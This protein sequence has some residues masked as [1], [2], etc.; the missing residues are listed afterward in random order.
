MTTEQVQAEFLSATGRSRRAA[1]DAALDVLETAENCLVFRTPDSDR[2]TTIGND[3]LVPILLQRAKDSLNACEAFEARLDL[4][5][6]AAERGSAEALYRWALLVKQGSEV[7]NSA[8]GVATAEET[9]GGGAIP[10]ALKGTVMASLWGG[11][12]DGSVQS[13][14]SHTSDHDR[15]TLAFLVAADMGH[16]PALTALAFTLLNGAGASALLL[17]NTTELQGWNLPVPASYRA[18]LGTTAFATALRARLLA[19][20]DSRC[21]APVWTNPVASQVAVE[22]DIGRS[23]LQAVISGR[24]SVGNIAAVLG[25]FGKSVISGCTDPSQLAQGL[26]EVAAMHGDAEAHQALYYRYGTVVAYCFAVYW[27]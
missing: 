7:G 1:V 8:C 6:D 17:H 9:N 18:G 26:L 12:A 23:V 10:S 14:N 16:A 5:A 13:G 22:S 2:A 3:P 4:Y 27:P 25:Q 24:D 15:A 20:L 21:S 11:S 19:G